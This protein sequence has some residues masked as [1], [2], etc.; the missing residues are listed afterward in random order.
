MGKNKNKFGLRDKIGYGIGNIG[1]DM[2][3]SLASSYFMVFYTNVL[4]V[5]A[6]AVGIL[7]GIAR[8]VDAF[9]DVG[10]GA[11]SD[12]SKERKDGK[13]KPW[14]KRMAIPV[15]LASILMYNIFITDWSM[16]AKLAY[17]AIT[18]LLWG[19]I[20]Y[21]SINIPYGSLAS[22]ISEKSED[23]AQLSTFRSLGSIAT[24]VITGLI[25]PNVIYTT[26]GGV[27]SN[28]FFV[29]AVIM[30]AIASLCYLICY[31]MVTERVS[32]PKTEEKFSFRQFGIDLK[33]L[34]KNKGF[35]GLMLSTLFVL[36]SLI[37]LNQLLQYL[38]KDYY[39]DTT[40][41]SYAMIFSTLGGLA[42]APLSGKITKK[43]GKK[44]AG[45]ISLILASCV[46]LGAFFFKVD[47]PKLMAFLVL[48]AAM[49]QSYYTMAMYSYVT[50]V[51]DDYQVQ[52]NE[53]K[54]GTIYAVYSFTR[55]LGQAIAGFFAGASLSWI[56]YQSTVGGGSVVQT[57]AVHEGIYK[58]ATIIPGLSL[59]VAG[60]ILLFFYPLN[61]KKV[62]ENAKLLKEKEEILND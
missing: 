37:S 11:I 28:N 3:F 19:S 54:D 55:K 51:I 30:A 33:E 16:T 57:A 15:G 13:F 12:Y 21:T 56:G 18:Y 14:L 36:V 29:V 1:N 32:L 31:F 20:C 17:M 43:Y 53:R 25:I 44:E 40:Y 35:L 41:L 42:G 34:V 46:Y 27:I 58:L 6:H 61:R 50:D 10:M 26:E 62:E 52:Y 48:L 7:F 2:T 9:T 60:L 24:G 5:S 4:G 59:L 49:L 22:V 23:R 45:A 39:M 38:Y 47:N 8:I